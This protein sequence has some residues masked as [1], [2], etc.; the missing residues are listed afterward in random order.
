[1]YTRLALAPLATGWVHMTRN[2]HSK[3][4]DVDDRWISSRFLNT[5]PVF[6]FFDTGVC[7]FFFFY[8]RCCF[9]IQVEKKQTVVFSSWR[10]GGTWGFL[11]QVLIHRRQCVF[12]VFY[13]CVGWTRGLAESACHTQE[14]TN[15]L[16]T[17]HTFNTQQVFPI[18]FLDDHLFKFSTQLLCPTLELYVHFFLPK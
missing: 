12:A 5:G 1:M 3:C 10:L 9:W 14:S 7:F 2:T 15:Q 17:I 8:G 6:C 18:W 11:W 4:S 16:P 13:A